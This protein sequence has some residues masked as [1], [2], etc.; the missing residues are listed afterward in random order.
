MSKINN[1]EMVLFWLRRARRE[2]VQRVAPPSHTEMANLRLDY[3]QRQEAL[4]EVARLES[5]AAANVKA[6]DLAIEFIEEHG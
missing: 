5:A 3:R 2:L 6:F 1:K 4:E